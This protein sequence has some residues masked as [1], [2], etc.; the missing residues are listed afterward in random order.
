MC[1]KPALDVWI[2]VKNYYPIGTKIERVFRKNR[3]VLT[4]TVVDFNLETK[5]YTLYWEEENE[6]T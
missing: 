2:Q 3:I 1:P 6:D 4:T 5:L